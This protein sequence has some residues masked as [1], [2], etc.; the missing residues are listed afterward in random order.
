MK[1]FPFPFSKEATSL[2]YTVDFFVRI[3]YNIIN[4]VNKG[5]SHG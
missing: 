5:E 2:L 3:W 4:I 1:I